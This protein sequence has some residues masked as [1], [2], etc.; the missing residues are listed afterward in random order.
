MDSIA[1]VVISNGSNIYERNSIASN[2]LFGYIYQM[3][4]VS[5]SNFSKYVYSLVTLCKCVFS[6]NSPH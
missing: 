3:N 6:S 5:A 1:N 2:S 4:L